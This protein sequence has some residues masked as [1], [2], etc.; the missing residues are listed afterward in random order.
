VTA[1]HAGRPQTDPAG[2]PIEVVRPSRDDVKR[3]VRELL[4]AAL[5]SPARA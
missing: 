5:D 3:R 2:Q 4:T 1:H